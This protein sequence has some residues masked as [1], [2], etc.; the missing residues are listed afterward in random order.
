MEATFRTKQWP[1][2]GTTYFRDVGV[3]DI[4]IQNS[5]LGTF[6]GE[7]GLQIDAHFVQKLEPNIT[8]FLDRSP[9]RRHITAP[10]Q[11]GTIAFFLHLTSESSQAYLP[12]P[13]PLHLLP[14]T[15]LVGL[16]EVQ[17]Q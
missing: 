2:L 16:L 11:T 14:L 7:R 8:L 4:R 5:E 12:G 6:K 3:V 17:R 13:F 10:Y 9:G 1:I 15:L